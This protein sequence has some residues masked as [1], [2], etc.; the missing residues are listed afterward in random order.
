MTKNRQKRNWVKKK[1]SVSY[2]MDTKHISKRNNSMNDKVKTTSLL[3]PTH[4]WLE[5]FENGKLKKFF[6]AQI[7][8]ICH[9]W[10]L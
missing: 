2:E 7:I 5:I 4:F 9:R 6:F 3:R 1:V 8:H 10:S